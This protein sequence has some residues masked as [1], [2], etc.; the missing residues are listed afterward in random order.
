MIKDIA[1][2]EVMA[3]NLSL[4][5]EM[6]LVTDTIKNMTLKELSFKIDEYMRYYNN[7]RK[8]WTRKKMTPV[9]GFTRFL[10]K[11]VHIIIS[12]TLLKI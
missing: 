2:G 4:Y 7:E 3:W 8:Q 12:L 9:R 10:L 1:S 11:G 6:T 5:L